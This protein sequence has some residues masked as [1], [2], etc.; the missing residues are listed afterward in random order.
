MNCLF[1]FQVTKLQLISKSTEENVNS[2]NSVNKKQ[3]LN[4]IAPVKVSSVNKKQHLN[5]AA[6]VKVNK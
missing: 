2:F 6:H 4:L 3:Y 1:L 5:S